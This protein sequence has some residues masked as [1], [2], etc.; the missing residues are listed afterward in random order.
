MHSQHKERRR[1][2]PEEKAEEKSQLSLYV[3][4]LGKTP[5]LNKQ[6][7]AELSEKI[8]SAK[9]KG[10]IDQEAEDHLFNANLRLVVFIAKDFAGRSPNFS[11]LELIHEGNLGLM[12]AVRGFDW[13]RGYRFSSYATPCIERIIKK[14]LHAE[15]EGEDMISIDTMFEDTL[16]LGGRKKPL[17]EHLEDTQ[18]VSPGVAA[19]QNSLREAVSKAL[20]KLKPD[21]RQIVCLSFL[22]NLSLR[23]IAERLGMGKEKVH[24]LLQRSL[25]KLS[26]N[27]EL[28]SFS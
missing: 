4:K 22:N 5:L 20:A 25:I 21:E 14:A 19:D 6:E 12:A 17:M 28:G 10:G 16:G 7:E 15:A 23:D 26:N 9:G 8:Q 1:Q 24:K 27:K 3:G 18:A 2:V 11:L 13:K